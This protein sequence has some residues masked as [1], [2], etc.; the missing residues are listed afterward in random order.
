MKGGVWK[1]RG[2]SFL[3]FD[4]FGN[5]TYT[6]SELFTEQGWIE[7]HLV[8]VRNTYDDSGHILES[9]HLQWD[10]FREQRLISQGKTLQ[11]IAVTHIPPWSGEGKANSLT[12]TV[13][14]YDHLGRVLSSLS[15]AVGTRRRRPVARSTYEYLNDGWRMTL[16]RFMNGEWHE[17]VVEE[18]FVRHVDGYEIE[19]SR[20]RWLRHWTEKRTLRKVHRSATDPTERVDRSLYTFALNDVFP[21]PV[22]A[23][24]SMTFE[25]P[26]EGRVSLEVFDPL[27]RRV[28]HLIEDRLGPGLH[29]V[30]IDVRQLSGGTYFLRLSFDRQQ[31]VGTMV[32][33]H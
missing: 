16:D 32:V 14:T 6:R 21:N 28:D 31:L 17:E 23:D 25:L 8:E 4:V 11:E 33:T 19:T 3:S 15:E 29:S 5:R 10:R 24:A 13:F 30:T 1:T 2:R 26:S 12:H 20:T 27:G 22:S 9:Y 7:N 18:K